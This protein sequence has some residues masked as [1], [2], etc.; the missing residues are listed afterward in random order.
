[1]GLSRSPAASAHG[2]PSLAQAKVASPTNQ[3]TSNRAAPDVSSGVLLGGSVGTVTAVGTVTVGASH[4][5]K[6][7]KAARPFLHGMVAVRP[8][9]TACTHLGAGCD[10]TWWQ[11]R[12]RGGRL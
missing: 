11:R 10:M 3:S 4:W 2:D 9:C 1:M 12:T 6:H 8:C 7:T 5:G